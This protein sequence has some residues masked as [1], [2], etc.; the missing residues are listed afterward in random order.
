MGKYKRNITKSIL[1]GLKSNP[2]VLITG[3]RQTGK[4]TLIKKISDTKA[5]YMESNHRKT[6]SLSLT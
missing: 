3:A 1:D 5:D 6:L 2:A 4:T